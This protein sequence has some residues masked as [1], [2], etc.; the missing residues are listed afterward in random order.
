MTGLISK[1][2][3]RL[4]EF[5]LETVK[6]MKTTL[7]FSLAF[8]IS[9]NSPLTA[10]HEDSPSEVHNKIDHFLERGIENG[11]AGAIAVIKNGKEIINKGYGLADQKK[12]QL[13][14][15]NTIFDIGSNTKQFTATAI[16]K[17]FEMGELNLEDPL[18]LYFEDL[19]EDK[20]NITIHQLLSHTSGIVDAIGNDFDETSQDKFFKQVFST[21]LLSEP[22]RLFSY[23]NIGY[24]IL[25]RIIELV[26]NAEYEA[27]LNKY[28]FTPAHMTQTGYLLPKWDTTNVSRSYNRGILESESPIF[29]YQRNG[30]ISWH[31][32]ANGG[33]NSTQ[34]DMLL[35]YE[36]LKS[37]TVISEESFKKLTTPYANY[38]NS[39]LNYGYG[40][41]IRSANNDLKRIAHNGSNGAY[42]HTLI[43]FTEEDIYISYATNANSEEVEYIAYDI[44]KMLL[45]ETFNPQP[46]KNNVYAYSL[47][48]ID[49][50]NIDKSEDLITLLK[51][52]YPDHFTNSRLLNSV[53]NILL[54][55]N[56]HQNWSVEIFKRNI[57]LYPNDGNLWDSLGDG[58]MSINKI[59]EASKSYQKAIDLG[60][61]DSQYKL[62]QIIKN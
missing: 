29:K 20:Q 33:I 54:M 46:I 38:P 45:D 5:C 31:L 48:F 34:N 22:G 21:P 30:T 7:I 36:A 62:D 13:N 3:N 19:P 59:D 42:A 25:G 17:L 41:T 49:K 1:H 51:Q 10:Q 56:K 2:Y 18:K 43:W 39:E 8:F 61:K 28:L 50:N 44:A 40:W 47:D 53:G 60:Y 14:K 15:P 26:G 12:Q 9:I 23:S 16:L 6:T 4:L 37:N 55:I 24:S 58:Y 27:F 32:K 11:F 52:K 57:E 35:W